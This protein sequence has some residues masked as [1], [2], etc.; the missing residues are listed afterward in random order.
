MY[1]P[2]AQSRSSDTHYDRGVSNYSTTPLWRKLGIRD[3]DSTAV[4]AP[5][6]G[7]LISDLPATT[8]AAPFA[9]V[10][11]FATTAAEVGSAFAEYATALTTT[12]G[13]WIAWPKK[14]SRIPNSLD[15]TTVQE[16][17]LEGGLVDNKSCAIDA[18]WQGLR[19]VRRLRD[20]A[21][22]TRKPGAHG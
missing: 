8:S 12:G 5:P 17:G 9:V 20:R 1:E 3:G 16:F 14:T 13:I 2:A 10:L 7:F 21:A 6:E 18:D 22:A 4:V 11:V 15:F 19:F